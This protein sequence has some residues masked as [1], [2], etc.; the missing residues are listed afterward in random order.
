MRRSVVRCSSTFCVCLYK[1]NIPIFCLNRRC[2]SNWPLRDVSTSPGEEDWGATEMRPRSESAGEPTAQGNIGSDQARPNRGVPSCLE[3]PGDSIGRGR[4][5]EQYR[6]GAHST[7]G[8]RHRHHPALAAEEWIVPGLPVHR[9]GDRHD[10]SPVCARHVAPTRASSRTCREDDD[11]NGVPA[12]GE[13]PPAEMKFPRRYS[14]DVE[15]AECLTVRSTF[16]DCRACAV[17][18]N[19]SARR[20]LRATRRP[21]LLEMHGTRLAIAMRGRASECWRSPGDNRAPPVYAN[22][23]GAVSEQTPISVLSLRR[24]RAA[25]A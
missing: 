4:R 12:V 9:N 24:G 21:D 10:R 5:V 2:Q 22:R 23:F 3:R 15:A 8:L 19:A 20:P 7:A 11:Y 6:G 17:E 14:E 13:K 16:V 1:N 25:L 18:R